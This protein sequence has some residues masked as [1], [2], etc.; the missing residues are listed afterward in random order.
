MAQIGALGL[1]ETRGMAALTAAADAM[2]KAADVRLCGRHG[3]G[4]GWV[5]VAVAGEVA[6]VQVAVRAGR[7]AAERYGE[8]VESEIVVR[9]QMEELEAMPHWAGMAASAGASS[10]A[11]GML[12]TRTLA[13]L[14]QGADAMVKAA[15]V[16]LGGWSSIG[17]ALVHFVVRGDVAAVRTALEAGRSAAARAGEVHAALAIAR[18]AAGMEGLLP[19]VAPGEPVEAGALGILETVGYAGAVGGSDAM[20]KAA[21]VEVMRLSAA[22]GGRIAVLARGSLDAVQA[23]VEA[24]TTAA[25]ES[26]E[27]DHACVV[28]R[29]AP[30]LIA[31]FG[32]VGPDSRVAGGK[33]LG[34]IET[35]S[36]VALVKAVDQML[37]AAPVEFEG[38][39]KVGYF[40]TAAVVRGDVGAVRSA[41][42]AGAAAVLQYGELVSAHVIP[43]PPAE[44]EGRLPHR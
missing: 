10:E 2:L 4:S 29:P 39:H 1:V 31:R 25:R 32:G 19:A 3:I 41:V 38:R 21:A 26:G 37:K 36:T 27:L 17:G 20:V 15:A 11:L 34:L 12:E 44:L 18:P 23:A 28:S 42:D 7:L 13:P 8:L 33:A 6:A 40:L 30:Q 14:I 5:T 43:F 22:S 16:E 24:G 35:R 9:P